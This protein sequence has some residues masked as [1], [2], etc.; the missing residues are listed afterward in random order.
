MVGL[1]NA[2]GTAD[3]PRAVSQQKTAAATPTGA[4]QLALVL[5]AEQAVNR[6]LNV[7][8]QS[9]QNGAPGSQQGTAGEAESNNLP[10]SGS[11]PQYGGTLGLVLD[12]T[13]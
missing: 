9:I 11:G 1:V 7:A 13:A 4:E 5:N 3:M 6:V 10:P 12:V 2:I 8:I